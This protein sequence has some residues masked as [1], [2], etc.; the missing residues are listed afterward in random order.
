M[1]STDALKAFYRMQ[2]F[3]LFVKILRA[4]AREPKLGGAEGEE[5]DS[6]MSMEPDIGSIPGPQDNDLSQRQTLP[7]SESAR[8][9]ASGIFKTHSSTS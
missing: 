1:I 2:P 3:F 6:P 5:A 8:C 4:S 7:P 9:P